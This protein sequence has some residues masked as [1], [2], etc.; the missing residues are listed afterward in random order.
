MLAE[1]ERD[2][3]SGLAL[4]PVCCASVAKVIRPSNELHYKATIS[5][6]A[7]MSAVLIDVFLL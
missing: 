3:A 4:I 6:G 7:E 5:K 1:A 2:L